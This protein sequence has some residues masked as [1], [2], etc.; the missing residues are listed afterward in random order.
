MDPTNSIILE[1]CT[2]DPVSKQTVKNVVPSVSDNKEKS[3]RESFIMKN[4]QDRLDDRASEVLESDVNNC[5]TC[6]DTVSSWTE[7]CRV[8]ANASKRRIQIFEEEGINHQLCNKIHRYLPIRV[9]TSDTLPLQLCYHCAITLLSWH[10][11]VQGCID[12]E[13]RLTKMQA[14]IEKDQEV[15]CSTIIIPAYEEANLNSTLQETSVKGEPLPEESVSKGEVVKE[16]VTINPER[17]V[18]LSASGDGAAVAVKLVTTLERISVDYDWKPRRTLIFCVFA[19]SS[20]RCRESLPFYVRSR[21]LAYLALHGRNLQG[22]PIVVA[23]SSNKYPKAKSGGL[24]PVGMTF[25][26]LSE[27][28]ELIV[29]GSE[30]VRASVLEAADDLRSLQ[31]SLRRRGFY[32]PRLRTDMPH[33]VFAFLTDQN[34]T[35]VGDEDGRSDR[36]RWATMAQ[37]VGTSLWSLSESLTLKWDPKLLNDGID[38]VLRDENPLASR[39]ARE[40]LRRAVTNLIVNLE[41]INYRVDTTEKSKVLDVRMINDLLMELDRVLLCPEKDFSSGTDLAW[42]YLSSQK[43]PSSYSSRFDKMQLCFELANVMLETV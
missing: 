26:L 18:V 40:N 39:E 6:S 24:P 7:M 27:N 21:V 11:L 16:L 17:F 3:E 4:I 28:G 15:L 37:I 43:S 22:Q 31:D 19:G 34:G 33:A 29:S 25:V 36:T 32:L 23:A 1:S 14:L 35:R 10:K 8:C 12:A 42:F 2:N 13:R 30:M 5:V 9:S 38:D 20:D 41:R